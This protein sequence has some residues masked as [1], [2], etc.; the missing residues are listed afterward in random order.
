[1]NNFNG[2]NNFRPTNSAIIPGF[3]GSSGNNSFSGPSNNNIRPPAGPNFGGP[4]N[5]GYPQ[6]GNSTFIGPTNSGFRPSGNGPFTNSFGS[7]PNN[8]PS[9]SFNGT[10]FG[11]SGP[12][13]GNMTNF[14]TAPNNNQWRNS[15]GSTKR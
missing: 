11:Y 9:G 1:M 4:T 14:N 10:S 7:G 8:P 2:P 13:G 3:G 5:S 12:M 6:P 15:T